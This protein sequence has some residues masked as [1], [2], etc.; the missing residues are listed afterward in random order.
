MA[1]AL[2]K[3]TAAGTV[4]SAARTTGRG[5]P[6]VQLRID[7]D[8]ASGRARER[9]APIRGAAT[10]LRVALEQRRDAW[11][12]RSAC[13]SMPVDPGMNQN[14]SQPPDNG[15][16]Q[17]VRRSRLDLDVAIAIRK[18]AEVSERRPA[19]DSD[20]RESPVVW[21]GRWPT[22]TLDD[23]PRRDLMLS[24]R[25]A[26]GRSASLRSTCSSPR[27]SAAKPHA[28]TMRRSRRRGE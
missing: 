24:D 25:G 6:R 27:I 13:S 9:P 2:A 12:P 4:T 8:A 17:G 11:S 5:Q 20:L 19:L 26:D 23:F 14:A 16:R 3:E 10:I 1:K 18:P 28:T 22:W 7:D 15:G 21:L